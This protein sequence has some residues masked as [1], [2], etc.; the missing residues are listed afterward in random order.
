MNIRDF[1]KKNRHFGWQNARRVRELSAVHEAINTRAHV[2]NLM[3]RYMRDGEIGIMVNGMDCDC[4]QF[5]YGSVIRV[6]SI[7]ELTD[8][9]EKMYEYS[10]GPLNISYCTPEQANKVKYTSRDLAA[11]AFEDG[12]SHVVYY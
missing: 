5:S 12:H 4:V 8:R 11:E 6:N 2:Y 7:T 1:V 3:R 9:I 10:D